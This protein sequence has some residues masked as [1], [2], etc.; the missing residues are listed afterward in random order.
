MAAAIAGRSSHKSDKRFEFGRSLQAM[1]QMHMH[2]ALTAG[3]ALAMRLS[4]QAASRSARKLT[5]AASLLIAALSNAG[6][7]GLPTTQFLTAPGPVTAVW[8]NTGEDKVTQD[9]LRTA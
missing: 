6:A 5:L 3:A 8:A 9:E 4:H 1:R 2:A 7:A